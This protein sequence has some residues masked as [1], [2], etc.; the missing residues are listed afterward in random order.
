MKRSIIVLLLLCSVLFAK[1]NKTEQRALEI[2]LSEDFWWGESF[3]TSKAAKQDAHHQLLKNRALA[4]LNNSIRSFVISKME[5]QESEGSG[6]SSYTSKSISISSAHYLKNVRYL[7]YTVKKRHYILA[8]LA[9]E[10]YFRSENDVVEKLQNLL[11]TAIVARQNRSSGYLDLLVRCFLVSQSISKVML[12][13]G[14]EL[15]SWL[16][17]TIRNELQNAVI[18]A[19]VLRRGVHNS[20]PILFTCENLG[21]SA[22]LLVSVPQLGFVDMKMVDGK[23]QMFYE[24]LPSGKTM[25]INVELKPDLSAI[26]EDPLL[27]DAASRSRMGIIR[28]LELDFSKHITVNWTS[29]SN[30]FE[31]EFE[32]YFWGLSLAGTTWDFGDGNSIKAMD[33]PVKHR[34]SKEGTYDVSLRMNDDIVISRQIRVLDPVSEQKNRRPKEVYTLKFEPDGK[35]RLIAQNPSKLQQITDYKE[36]YAYLEKGK[37]DGQLV[38]GKLERGADLNGAWIMIFE[39]DASSRLACLKPKGQ[40]HLNVD[41]QE[42]IPNIFESYKGKLGLYVRYLNEEKP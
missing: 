28:R 29:K 41:T 40:T 39:P 35:T 16:N 21:L 37:S 3:D 34:Y 22:S 19:E 10:D 23:L 12:H 27:A 17:S 38:W 42:N 9:E 18:K 30:G 36:L 26:K 7:E 24:A 4:D 8:Y 6:N 11:N 14:L 33:K 25:D 20:Y 31:V 2:K 15:S 32:P 13:D 5:H 1:V